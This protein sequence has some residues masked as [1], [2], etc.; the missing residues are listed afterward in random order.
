MSASHLKRLTRFAL[1]I[2]F[3]WAVVLALDIFPGLRGG[4]GWRWPYVFPP[5]HP[6]R[7][8]LLALVLGIYLL[9]AWLL[10]KQKPALT[11]IWAVAGSVSLT[12]LVLFAT[13]QQ[14][15]SDLFT[16]SASNLTTGWHYAAVEVDDFGGLNETLSRWPEFI[17]QYR[18]RA[19]HVSTSPPGTV[20]LYHQA[21]VLLERFPALS[22][23]LAG[24][25]RP[26]QCH[27]LL[28]VE[29]TD[30]E[31]ASTWLGI[32][33]PLWGALA[34]FP[35]Y[36]L[37]KRAYGAGTARTAVIWWA[38]VPSMLMFTPE[39][40]TVYPVLSLAMLALLFKGLEE[41]KPVLM[42]L[43]GVVMSAA[44]FVKLVFLP[45]LFMAGLLALGFYVMNRRSNGYSWHW[46]V[47]AGLW[48]GA[49]L[50]SVW[51]VYYLAYQVTPLEIYQTNLANHLDLER[52]YF[53]WLFLHVYDFSIFTGLPMMIFAAASAWY[54]GKAL[55]QTR[56][57]QAGYLLTLAIAVTLFLMDI[58]G[59]SRG[60][61]GRLWLFMAPLF[62]LMAASIA[63]QDEGDKV[64]ITIA[65][66]QAVMVL[67]LVTFVHVI[68]SGLSSPPEPPSQAE[69]PPQGAYLPSGAVFGEKVQLVNFAGQVETT[70][71]GE[72]Q[73]VLWLNWLSSGQI[74]I[75]Y[76]LSLIPVAP[77][78]QVLDA[79]V[80]Q[81]FDDAYPVTCWVPASGGIEDRVVIPL[82]A[83]ADDGDWWVSLSLIDGK[84]GIKLPVVLPGG[85]QDEQVGLGPVR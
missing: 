24:P 44:L 69:I 73:L 23:A 66:A 62:L 7:I 2:S 14:G 48:F 3:V 76:Y 33:S 80:V 77:N 39:P 22:S 30:A 38:L 20:L 26:V 59:T 56:S 53:P 65:A 52:P 1:A 32:L 83:G 63:D 10:A 19:S 79:A 50:I 55:K 9:G 8:A 68:D 28:L 75:P 37:G 42:V 40:S 45:L 21:M 58:T 27:N 13:G 46:P 85:A 5:E 12:L 17:T 4:F 11:V 49:G 43:S 34:A 70:P 41:N 54:A 35:L 25:L 72:K 31:L 18:E 74:D 16:R 78:G 57:L 51:L 84:T 71:T 64:N 36:W 6:W 82:P 60:E 15:I 47:S 67:V 81:P 61:T 29:Y